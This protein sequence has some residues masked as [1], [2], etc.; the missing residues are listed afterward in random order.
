MLLLIE[1]EIRGRICHVFQQYAEAND[2]SMKNYDKNKEP[3]CLKYCDINNLY[4]WEKSLK[5]LLGGFEWVEE[6]CQFNEDFKK[7]L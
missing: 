5:L 2:K 3:S 1:K 4:G 6:T 7:N